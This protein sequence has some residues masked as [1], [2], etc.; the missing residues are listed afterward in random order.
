MRKFLSGLLLVP[1]LS[2]CWSSKPIEDLNII[3]GSAVDK[4][5]DGKI[6][7]TL[8]Y[9]VP[10]ALQTNKSGG[11]ST[12]K[13]YVNITEKGVSLEPIGWE[14]TLKKEGFIFGAHQKTIVV[15]SDVA[16]KF[17]LEELTDLHYRDVDIR[18]SAFVFIAKGRAND[19]L[20]MEDTSIPALHINEIANQQLTT[21][22][23]KPVTLSNMFAKL[24]SSTSFL[25]QQ[26]VKTEK[27]EVK[28]NGAAVIKGKTGKMIG[29]FNKKEIEGINW[30]TGESKS[31]VVK[32]YDSS[33]ERPIFYEIKTLKSKITPKVTDGRISFS[34][35]I[36]S[37][38]RIAEYWNPHELPTFENK[39]VKRIERMA[40]KEVNRLVGK[41]VKKMQH[42]YKVDVAGFGNQ[43]RIHYP[44]VWN[45]VKGEWDKTFSEAKITYE[46]DLSIKDY[47][48]IGK[49]N[50]RD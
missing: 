28:L 18:G 26:I 47:G 15:A 43:L 25:M 29:T 12:I 21:R 41:V 30:L 5:E 24:E 32:A 44:R 4:E 23:L 7:S 39:N 11:A 6:S 40:E 46:T 13:P 2:G 27:G 16:K 50:T 35:L 37:D 9:V 48:M 38:G 42:E 14:S 36:T 31:G 22:L 20:E 8:Q 19:T 17:D 33:K 10:G 49:K 34:V 45:E 1:L 3:V